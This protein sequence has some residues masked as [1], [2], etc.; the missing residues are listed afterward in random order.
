M[1]AGHAAF[2]FPNTSCLARS[3]RIHAVDSILDAAPLGFPGSSVIPMIGV[4]PAAKIY[5][6][7]VFPSDGAGAPSSRIIAA[8]DRVITM[9][10]NFLAGMPSAPVSGTG[11]EDDPFVFNSLDI[12][13][14]NMSLGGPTIFAGGALEDVLTQQMLSVGITPTISAGN[15]GPA[16]LSTG[17]PSTGRGSLTMAAANTPAHERILRDQPSAAKPTVCRL[18][19]GLL[20]R[21]NNTIQTAFFSSRGPTADGRVGVDLTTAG[22]ANFVQGANGGLALVAGTSFA[23]PTAAGAA[24]LLRRAVLSASATQIRNA[25]IVGGNRRVLGDNSTR[26]DQ[27]RG[28]LDVLASVNFLRSGD[29][30]DQIVIN[31]FSDEVKENVEAVGLETRKIEP[32]ETIHSQALNL[33]PGQRREFIVE[34][35]KNVGSVQINL[36]SVAPEL[37]PAQQNR[38]FGDDVIFSVHQAK[39]SAFGDY[40][41]FDFFNEPASFTIDNPEPGFMR[42]TFTGDWTNAGRVS[43]EFMMTA[44]LTSTP[45]FRR[46][47]TIADGQILVIPFNVPAGVNE[48]AFE[49]TWKHDWSAY[50]TNDLDLILVDPDG[51]FNFDGATL[52]GLERAVVKKPRAGT[53]LILVDGFTVFG[54]IEDEEEVDE[55]ATRT[56]KFRV[57]VFLK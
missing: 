57:H 49:L 24:A 54:K 55:K 39:T 7:K 5:A 12:Q 13:V 21:P 41:I 50:P 4:A 38:I 48:A 17:S 40:P 18:G 26:F 6:L 20:Y 22:F 44:T 36:T 23:A 34:I 43:A 1:I 3:V 14:A 16:G 33:V 29:V 32:G 37:P 8:M 25:L 19:R 46:E 10:K 30:S 2:L 51:T 15:E 45:T 35:P 42:V 47:G 9:K 27:G 56:D 52:N 31:E 53:W 28:F 11:T